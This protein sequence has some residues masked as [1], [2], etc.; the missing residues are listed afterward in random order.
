MSI[1][2]N[3]SRLKECREKLGISKMEAAKRMQLSQPA[4]LRYESGDR[5]PSVQ[6]LEV[7]AHVLDTSTEYLM[8]LTDDPTPISYTIS[9]ST[10]PELF[11]IIR[12]CKNP[13]SDMAKRLM[14]YA[15]KLAGIPKNTCY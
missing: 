12:L 13:E 6:T 15:N 2:L 14:A 11:E 10:D 7:I 5:T 9:K 3:I 1:Y 4:Y 8:N